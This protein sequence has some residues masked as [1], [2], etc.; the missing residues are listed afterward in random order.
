M[1]SD[2][3]Q[4]ELPVFKILTGCTTVTK[5]NVL[6]FLWGLEKK[7]ANEKK[8]FCTLPLRDH[9]GLLTDKMAMSVVPEDLPLVPEDLPLEP[10]IA[11]TRTSP[12]GNCLFNAVSLALVGDET[13]IRAPPEL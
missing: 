1:S 6:E 10:E 12:D 5:D 11:A 3:D 9:V 2:S 7:N 8:F 4:E 13:Q